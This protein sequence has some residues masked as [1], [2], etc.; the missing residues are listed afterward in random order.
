MRSPSSSLPMRI[1]AVEP[2]GAVLG[3]AE[4]FFGANFSA[5]RLAPHQADA[6][7]FLLSNRNSSNARAYDLIIL[8]AFD[9][10]IL[11]EDGDEFGTGAR[12]PPES[13]VSD[14]R[15][16]PLS[17]ECLRSDESLLIINVYGNEAW[18]RAVTDKISA[19]SSFESHML[20]TTHEW[21]MD[22]PLDRHL[23]RNV[24]VVI[25]SRHCLKGLS[26]RLISA[27]YEPVPVP[28]SA[29]LKCQ[30]LLHKPQTM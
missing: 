15:W 30:Y 21:N 11:D 17:Q 12:A 20:L 9:G 25:G 29:S 14:K 16:L 18:L 3:A 2:D 4:R 28:P 26:E 5:D 27:T 23:L 7:S 6:I 1:D 8:D 19:N 13:V 24:L 10:V 22:D